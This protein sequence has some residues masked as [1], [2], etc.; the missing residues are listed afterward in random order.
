MNTAQEL[1]KIRRALFLRQASS[2][3]FQPKVSARA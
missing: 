2:Q 3:T 1:S